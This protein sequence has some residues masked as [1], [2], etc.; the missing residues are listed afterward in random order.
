MINK[1]RA[2]GGISIDWLQLDE[3]VPDILFR[4]ELL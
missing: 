4:V 1:Y 3:N 2:V